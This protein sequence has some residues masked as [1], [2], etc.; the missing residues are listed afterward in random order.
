MNTHFEDIIQARLSYE[1]FLAEF[2]LTEKEVWAIS[3]SNK[4]MAALPEWI[5]TI[6]VA[7]SPI[8]GRGLFAC[9]DFS[10]GELLGPARYENGKRTAIG[11]FTNHGSAEQANVMFVAKDGGSIHAIAIKPVTN[12]QEFLVHYPQAMDVNGWGHLLR[13]QP[14]IN[15]IQEVTQLY[16]HIQMEHYSDRQKVDIIH[17]ILERHFDNILDTF[18]LIN[19]VVGNLYLRELVIPAGCAIVGKVHLR[20][21]V[22]LCISGDITVLTA[23]GMKR[24]VSGYN[25]TTFA[26]LKRLGYAHKVTRWLTVHDIGEMTEPKTISN[27]ESFLF[28]DSDISWVNQI[29][30]PEMAQECIE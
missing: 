3:S 28:G 11:R 30:L 15:P 25:E 23:D 7:F 10:I 17:W 2:G 24:V 16:P 4:D 26:G 21:H 13:V 9:K 29:M 6:R 20:D 14:P 12:G 1:N 19:T 5:E 18:E 27:I 22:S 8:A